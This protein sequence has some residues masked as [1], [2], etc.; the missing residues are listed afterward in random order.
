MRDTHKM[1]L[2]F[3][4]CKLQNNIHIASLPYKNFM[5]SKMGFLYED[6]YI[7]Q[8]LTGCLGQGRGRV[9]GCRVL[10]KGWEGRM[11]F[12]IYELAFTLQLAFFLLFR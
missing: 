10:R 2:I 6:I 11:N 3:L 12:I 1:S 9:E 8:V 4:K 7:H 5:K